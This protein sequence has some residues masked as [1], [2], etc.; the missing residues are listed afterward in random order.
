MGED[1]LQHLFNSFNEKLPNDEELL[2]RISQSLVEKLSYLENHLKNLTKTFLEQKDEIFNYEEQSRPCCS[3]H[4]KEFPRQ[5]CSII[6]K[7]S[8]GQ[9][10]AH[11]AT[12]VFKS[13]G[14]AQGKDRICIYSKDIYFLLIVFFL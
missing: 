14:L 7:G 5:A 10:I 4:D 1:H 13:S 6:H 2:S 3:N 9:K 8:E 11:K 12:K